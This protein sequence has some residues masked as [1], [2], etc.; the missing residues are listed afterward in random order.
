MASRDAILAGAVDQ[1]R[2]AAVAI[3]EPGTVGDHLGVR[4]EAERLATHLF[5]CTAPAY[6]GWTWAVTVARVPR[7]R[8]V[9]VCEAHLLP[10]PDAL[11]SPDWLPYAQRLQPGD[12]GPGDVL[13]YQADDA[14]LE[15]GFEAT[16][17]DDVDQLAL[18]ELGLGRV[19]VLSPAG[20]EAAAQRWYDGSH[21]PSSADASKAQAHC[22]SCG[23]FLPMSGALRRL[24]GVCAHA[25]S[26]SDGTVVSLDHGCGAHSETD[27]VAEPPVPVSA[28]LVDDLCWESLV[29]GRA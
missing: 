23:Y 21:G 1:A 11:L 22:S 19:R 12:V 15:V 25:W 13:P 8:R 2:D 26:P 29:E 27:V 4:M 5:V 16:G 9:T 14:N 6:R 3:A 17:Q 20:L 7:S 28:P 10:G 24:F 18:T